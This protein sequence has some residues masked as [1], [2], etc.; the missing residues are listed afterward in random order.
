MTFKRK[1][2]LLVHKSMCRKYSKIKI[3]YNLVVIIIL[4]CGCSF[5]F[6]GSIIVYSHASICYT[7]SIEYNIDV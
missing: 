1:L 7:P 2:I 3:R 5:L 6:W 4:C